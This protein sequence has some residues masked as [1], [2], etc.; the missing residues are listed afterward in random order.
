MVGFAKY[1][2][3]NYDVARAGR[4]GDWGLNVTRVPRVEYMTQMS[5]WNI[6]I[7][8]PTSPRVTHLQEIWVTPGYQKYPKLRK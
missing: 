8:I 6:P 5:S 3:P 2:F 1:T 7:C 4:R